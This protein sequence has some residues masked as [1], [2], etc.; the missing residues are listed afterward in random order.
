MAE[1]ALSV[2]PEVTLSVT[3]TVA[4]V[5]AL[6]VAPEATESVAEETLVVAVVEEAG[7]AVLTLTRS[8]PNS[9]STL[10]PAAAVTQAVPKQ[11]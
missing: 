4:E 2:A 7:A 8:T 3:T 9:S 6:S 11:F 1:L 10:Q 5:I